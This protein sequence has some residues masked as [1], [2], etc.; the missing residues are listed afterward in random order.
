[1]ALRHELAPFFEA[2]RA[3]TGWQLE[4]VPEPLEP[5]PPWNYEARARELLSAATSVLD[6]GTGGGEVLER[7]LLGSECK[8]VATEAWRVNAP[9]AARRLGRRVT[10]VRASSLLPFRARNFDLVLSR[11]EEIAPKEIARMLRPG[12][13]FLSQQ[14][15]PDVWPELRSIFPDMTRF[16]DHFVDYPEGLA[17]AGLE[18]TATREF[19]HRV[20][21]RALGHFVY[22]LA[23]A[24][25]FM[26]PGFSLETH[27]E[28]LEELAAWAGQPGGLVLTE[29]FTL[30]EARAGGATRGAPSLP[31]P[32]ESA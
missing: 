27:A 28:A 6:L 31:G 24:A 16:P 3:L 12:G 15:V 21:Y 18:I 9:I 7:V 8:A 10:I 5:G 4:F 1:M 14:V 17:R 32:R 23:V 22:H 30:L 25:P 29:G 26:L 13:R 11:H 2:A 19:R 20:R